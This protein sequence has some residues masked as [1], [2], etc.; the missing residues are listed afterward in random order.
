MIG[1]QESYASSMLKYDEQLPILRMLQEYENKEMLRM[2]VPSHKGKIEEWG[3]LGKWDITEIEGSD[4]LHAPND[5]IA[6]A[7]A[8]YAQA[9]GAEHTFFLVN[10]ATVGVLAM[11]M[12]FAPDGAI[13]MERKCHHSAVHAAILGG[14]RYAYLE[15]EDVLTADDV[16]RGME[17]APPEAP[18]FLTYP[19]YY[20]RCCDIEAIARLVHQEGRL[21]LVDQ[22]HGAHFAFDKRLPISAGEAGADIWVD[23]VHK[24]GLALTQGACLQVGKGGKPWEEQLG[25]L[26]RMLETSSPSYP[27]MASIDY[28]RALLGEKK[29]WDAALKNAGSFWKIILSTPGLERLTGT[30]MAAQDPMRLAV[31]VINRGISGFQAQQQLRQMGLEA[32]MAD[33]ETVVLVSSI[34]DRPKDMIKA[35]ECF[36]RLQDG[37]NMEFTKRKRPGVPP[38]RMEIRQAFFAPNQRILLEKCEGRIA[39]RSMEVYP[40]GNCVIMPGEVYTKEIITYV[41][42]METAGGTILGEAAVVR[43]T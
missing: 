41:Q 20:G 36:A 26:L 8:L 38:K 5:A 7:Q 25:M 2:H 31:R 43:E 37:G 9:T 15:A 30:G 42:E 11:L 39:A 35:G 12:L 33:A 14:L 4:N 21:L 17:M 16:R 24:T 22:S 34:L 1:K 27:I 29:R 19:D 6:R 18:V 10:G 13:I 40:P 32:E 28:S 3:N 23:S